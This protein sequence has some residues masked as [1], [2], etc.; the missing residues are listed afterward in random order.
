MDTEKSGI[1]SET[2]A[3][4]GLACEGWWQVCGI[5]GT[6]MHLYISIQNKKKTKLPF[7]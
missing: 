2:Q 5:Y 1:I 6:C 7:A 4:G 3:A